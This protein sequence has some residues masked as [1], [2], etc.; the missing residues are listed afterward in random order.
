MSKNLRI[1]SRLLLKMRSPP[2]CSR[3]H[4]L[5]GAYSISDSF[6]K[7]G[8]A[9]Y[10]DRIRQ[11]EETNRTTLVVSHRD[12]LNHDENLANSILEEYTRFEPFLKRSVAAAVQRI[13]PA[14]L[15]FNNQVRDFYVAFSD[16]R[17]ESCS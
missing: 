9:I 1:L 11:M 12:M 15:T 13:I 6:L 4:L 5:S 16:L 17:T 2:S 7:D 3:N 8:Q 10:F 14:Y